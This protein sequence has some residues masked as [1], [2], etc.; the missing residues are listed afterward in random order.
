MS[1]QPAP[2]IPEATSQ[3]R[4]QAL[5]P[6]RIESVLNDFREWLYEA[7]AQGDETEPAPEA[8]TIDLHTLLAQFTALRHEVN[9]QTRAVR[10]QQE[11]N[12]ETLLVLQQALEKAAPSAPRAAQPEDDSIRAQL[13]TLIEIHDALALAAREAQRVRE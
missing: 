4:S 6:E 5:I 12:A 1:E 8:E 11:Q 10:A 13:R 9:L 2:G 7:A 3:R